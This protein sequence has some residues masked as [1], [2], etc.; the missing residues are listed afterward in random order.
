MAHTYPDLFSEFIEDGAVAAYA[1]DTSEHTAEP[2]EVAAER[3]RH[4]WRQRSEAVLRGAGVPG[5]LEELED[6]RRMQAVDEL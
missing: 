4:I 1:A 3:R 5:L 6:L 2:W